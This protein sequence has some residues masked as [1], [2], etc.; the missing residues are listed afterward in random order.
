MYIVGRILKPQGIKGEVKTEVITSFPEHFNDLNELFIK[1]DSFEPIEIESRRFS[2]K[3]VFLKFKGIESRNDA[4]ILRNEYLFVPEKELFSLE[5][6]EFYNHQL[7]GLKV[8][9]EENDYIGE[10]LE[11]ENYPEHDVLV[12][13]DSNKEEHLIPF[14]KDIIREVD[15]E[16]Q[17]VKIHL[18]E[19]L[20][21]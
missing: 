3:F 15:V 6:D 2:N 16:S 11:I 9:S 8:Y 21:G 14:V 7:I 13:K 10:I 4:E 5:E 1:K 19:G 20:L 12:V 18:I 17:K